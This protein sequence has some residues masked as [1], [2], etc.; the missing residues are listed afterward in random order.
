MDEVER[1]NGR[2]RNVNEGLPL[3]SRMGMKRQGQRIAERLSGA[4]W[5]RASGLAGS[6]VLLQAGEGDLSRAEGRE[7]EQESAPFRSSESLLSGL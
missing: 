7:P 5:R 2:Y 6:W 4:E 3:F 1:T